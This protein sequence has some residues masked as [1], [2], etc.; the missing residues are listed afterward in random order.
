ETLKTRGTVPTIAAG[1]ELPACVQRKRN[2]QSDRARLAGTRG[3]G[4]VLNHH[5]RTGR[6]ASPGPSSGAGNRAVTAVGRGA[7]RSACD[8]GRRIRRRRLRGAGASPGPP[9]VLPPELTS[10]SPADRGPR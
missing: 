5:G 7:D 3:P 4:R 6:P 8:G 10:L 1:Q 9:K 2:T